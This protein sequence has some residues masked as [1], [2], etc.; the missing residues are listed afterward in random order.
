MQRINSV[1]R[2][3]EFYDATVK[4]ARNNFLEISTLSSDDSISCECFLRHDN[5]S[6][7]SESTHFDFLSILNNNLILIGS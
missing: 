2:E 3:H 5:P 4:V 7:F 1:A 6:S